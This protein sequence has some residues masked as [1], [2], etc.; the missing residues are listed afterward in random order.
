[1]YQSWRSMYRETSFEIGKRF[2]IYV[3]FFLFFVICSYFPLLLSR[4]WI[5][6]ESFLLRIWIFYFKLFLATW[7]QIFLSNKFDCIQIRCLKL[8]KTL[9]LVNAIFQ[10]VLDWV[11]KQHDWFKVNKSER[12]GC[13]ETNVLRSHA[14]SACDFSWTHVRFYVLSGQAERLSNYAAHVIFGEWLRCATMKD[15]FCL[16]FLWILL[17]IYSNKNI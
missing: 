3:I 13:I 15:T 7:I 11:F 17:Y 6:K 4:I 12:I 9:R 10:A 8:N 2:I 16:R 5:E 1:M 14:R